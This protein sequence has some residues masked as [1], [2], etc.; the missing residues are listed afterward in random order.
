[1]MERRHLKVERLPLLLIQLVQREGDSRQESGG[2]HLEDCYL[3]LMSILP[4]VTASSGLLG[5]VEVI[6]ASDPEVARAVVKERGVG[7]CD[8]GGQ[9]KRVH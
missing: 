3:F 5:V 2:S 9:G 8:D 6:S 4:G 7:L 1:M